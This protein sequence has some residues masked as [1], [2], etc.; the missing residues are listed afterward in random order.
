MMNATRS[1]GKKRG[2]GGLTLSDV[3]D[4]ASQYMLDEVAQYRYDALIMRLPDLFD[5]VVT[6]KLTISDLK[7]CPKR[8]EYCHEFVNVLVQKFV[9]SGSDNFHDFISKYNFE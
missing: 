3:K 5:V 1:G 2:G 6:S 4:N 7:T 8:E 9:D